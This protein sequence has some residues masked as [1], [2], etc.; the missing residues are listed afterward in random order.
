MV[1]K[2]VA[3][4]AALLVAASAGSALAGEKWWEQS[5][6]VYPLAEERVL[7]CTATD[8]VG[9]IWEDGQTA[10]QSTS[11]KPHR[12]IV[13]VLSKEK[14]T[15][16]PTTGD[17]AGKTSTLTCR[18]PYGEYYPGLLVCG[19]SY[20]YGTSPWLFNGNKFVHAFVLGPTV[21][22]NDPNIW[23]SYGTCTGF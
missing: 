21:G 7:Y 1:P 13:K 16:T 3:I 10:G 6:L 22:G 15:V 8:S 18:K 17:V 11:F 2:T 14:R 12:Y 23:I 20:S 19:S 5:E 9:F 4:G